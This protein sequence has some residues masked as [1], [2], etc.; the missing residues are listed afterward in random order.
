MLESV[1][2]MTLWMAATISNAML[3]MPEADVMGVFRSATTS[4]GGP[5][6]KK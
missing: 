4:L 6:G 5:T 1:L 3:F 2:G